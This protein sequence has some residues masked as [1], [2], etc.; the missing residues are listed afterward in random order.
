[1]NPIKKQTV[2]SGCVACRCFTLKRHQTGPRITWWILEVFRAEGLESV[3]IQASESRTKGW[4][5][6]SL[7]E[8][9]KRSPGTGT[10]TGTWTVSPTQTQ[11]VI[12]TDKSAAANLH[13]KRRNGG[14]GVEVWS[15]HIRLKSSEGILL[16]DP[17]VLLSRFIGC[18]PGNGMIIKHFLS[19]NNKLTVETRIIYWTSR[20]PPPHLDGL[21][22][23]RS[24]TNI[25][26]ET[27]T[28]CYTVPAHLIRTR[29]CFSSDQI[30]DAVQ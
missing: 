20:G 4:S 11:M 9:T 19:F 30:R 13:V 12:F 22:E 2:S 29:T 27:G 21:W 24:K 5:R 25:C 16:Q 1:M 17:R 28:L 23:T 10:W 18:F 3:W 26:T 8:R 14:G 6:S 7:S 15:Q